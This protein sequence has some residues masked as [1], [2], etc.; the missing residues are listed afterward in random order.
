M[1]INSI[2]DLPRMRELHMQACN[3]P[4]RNNLVDESLPLE[5]AAQQALAAIIEAALANEDDI[6]DNPA[7]HHLAKLKEVENDTYRLLSWE[8]LVRFGFLRRLTEVV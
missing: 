3:K 7:S 4:E 6:L 8:I 5:P 1:P 2:A